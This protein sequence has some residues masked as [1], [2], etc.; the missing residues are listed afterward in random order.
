MIKY[1]YATQKDYKF[2]KEKDRYIS[3]DILKRKINCQEVIIAKDGEQNI[4][5]LRYGYF[6]DSVP[7]MNMLHVL[8]SYR[9]QDIGT[10]L[11]TYWENEMS[12]KGHK[13]VITSTMAVE[14]SQQFYRKCGYV[15]VGGFL[16]E[17]EGLEVMFKKDL[18]K[19]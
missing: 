12:S 13:M 14:T 16:L 19:S 8:D 11:V 4:G 10:A 3:D 18:I 6:W 9:G 7:Y 2:L 17:K 1:Q 15:D 5:W